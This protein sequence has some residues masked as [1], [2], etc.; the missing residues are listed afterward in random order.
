MRKDFAK[1]YKTKIF[2]SL[3]KVCQLLTNV[4][5]WICFVFFTTLRTIFLKGRKINVKNWMLKATQPETQQTYCKLRIL[6]DFDLLKLVN[7]LMQVC[8]LHQVAASLSKSDLIAL[9]TVFADL[10]E[11]VTTTCSKLVDNKS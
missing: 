4:L 1:K 2:I 9:D 8:S 10:L 6:P 11:V 5:D 3:Y 7:K